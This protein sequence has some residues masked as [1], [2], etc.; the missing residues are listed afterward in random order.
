NLLCFRW[1][2]ARGWDKCERADDTRNCPHGEVAPRDLLVASGAKIIT[3]VAD[4]PHAASRRLT[5]H[6]NSQ[7]HGA[8]SGRDRRVQTRSCALPWP[9]DGDSLTRTSVRT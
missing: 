5:L 9:P 2:R 3:S 8:K 6:T 1:S 4:R 7:G